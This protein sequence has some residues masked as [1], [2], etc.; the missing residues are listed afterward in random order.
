[1][2]ESELEYLEAIVEAFTAEPD[3]LT[4]WERSFLTDVAARVKK[5]GLET[6]MSARQ[7]EFIE[8]AGNKLQVAP[9]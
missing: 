3:R 1:M 4:A 8:K 5:Y 6:F 9:F 7:W 2:K